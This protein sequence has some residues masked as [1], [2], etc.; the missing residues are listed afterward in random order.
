VE[1]KWKTATELNNYGFEVQRNENPIEEDDESGWRR[2]G[3]VAGNGTCVSPKSYSFEDPL[4]EGSNTI[5]YRLMQI[6]RDGTTD[7][8]AIVEVVTGAVSFNL[9][10]NYPNPFAAQTT[11]VYSLRAENLVTLKVYDVLGNVVQTLVE[12]TQGAGS[13]VT[14]FD[15]A[16]LNL[17][18]GCYL[19]SLTAGSAVESR[20]MIY[21]P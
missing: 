2:V 5:R 4:I 19:V 1:L 6:D 15:P 8:S 17:K 12:E 10:Q 16:Q 21:I 18:P 13:Y 9:S 11:I 7:Y 3:F 20:T 14:R